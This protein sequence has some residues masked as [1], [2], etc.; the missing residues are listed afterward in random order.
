MTFQFGGLPRAQMQ[1]W[2]VH[3]HA[4]G[5]AHRWIPRGGAG[6]SADQAT[7][8]VVA[9]L[10]G[11]RFTSSSVSTPFSGETVSETF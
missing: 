6:L 10:T 3:P 9:L 2:V 11:T 4:P 7:V 1:L 5:R 8:K